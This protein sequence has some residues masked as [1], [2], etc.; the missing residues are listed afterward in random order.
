MFSA[1]HLGVV[2]RP[3]PHKRKV[4]FVLECLLF[5]KALFAT[6]LTH[7]APSVQ[8]LYTGFPDIEDYLFLDIC[9]PKESYDYDRANDCTASIH[10]KHAQDTLI[11][12][13]VDVTVTFSRTVRR[14]LYENWQPSSAKQE[15]A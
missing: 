5:D 9:G 1:P 7:H 6:N 4:A 2:L 3:Q 11:K 13:D 15:T 14:M 10:I 12:H 8:V